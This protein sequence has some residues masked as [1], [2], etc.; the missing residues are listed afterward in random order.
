MRQGAAILD[1][2]R[3]VPQFF[4]TG[5]FRS[6]GLE[7]VGTAYRLHNEVSVPYH[8]P[9]PRQYRRSDGDYALSN[10]GRFF[11]KMDFAHRPKH[12]RVLR[13]EIMV[14]AVDS[15]FDLDITFEAAEVP[16][17]IE[18]C[19]RRGGTLSGVQS[20]NSIDNFQLVEGFGNYKVG[21]D[22]ITFGPGNGA[23]PLQPVNMEPGEQY[24]Y[25]GGSLV[26]DG[27]RVYIT[28]RTPIR[29]VLQLHY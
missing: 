3:I 21:D 26:P 20:M 10:D 24:T 8:L 4:N 18:L 7:V 16:F 9:L 29:Y 19:F 6:D 17:T 13:T 23:G 14:S 28:G 22:C 12:F 11:S 1:S 5:H 25:R 2:V 15:G 27:I